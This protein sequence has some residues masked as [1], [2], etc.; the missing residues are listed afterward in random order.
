MDALPCPV[1]ITEGLLHFAVFKKCTVA[2]NISHKIVIAAN[3]FIS[4]VWRVTIIHNDKKME[5][6][7]EIFTRVKSRS[8]SSLHGPITLKL[9][10]PS[11]FPVNL[12][13]S[14]SIYFNSSSRLCSGILS[15]FAIAFCTI[16]QENRPIK[17]H[18]HIH[19][20]MKFGKFPLF[21][22]LLT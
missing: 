1:A 6:C 13:F 2:R 11:K 4:T 5:Y 19:T 8:Y 10:F 21:H 9:S 15:N 12:N 7:Y 20:M 14:S 16:W 18:T 22:N 3:D 17:H